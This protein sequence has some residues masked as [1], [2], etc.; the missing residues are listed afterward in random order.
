MDEQT[1]EKNGNT[2]CPILSSY[3]DHKNKNVFTRTP[4]NQKHMKTLCIH[5]IR[6]FLLKTQ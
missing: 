5:L 4:P 3:E 1:N 2:I 6:T